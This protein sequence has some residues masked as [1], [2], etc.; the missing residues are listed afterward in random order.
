MAVITGSSRGIGAATAEEMAAQG[1][2]I[3]VAYR[4]DEAAARSVVTACEAKGRSAVAVRVDVASADD[5]KSLFAAADELGR[6]G[7]LVNNAAMLLPPNRVDEC[8]ATS[9]TR[10]LAVNVVG[11]FLCARE[12]IIRMSTL[13]GGAGGSIVNV[14]S[15]GSRHGA[16]GEHVDYA[17]SKGALDAM[18]WG[19]AQE[20]A[21]EG[22]RVNAVRPGAVET[23]I[24]LVAGDRERVSRRARQTPLGRVG[25]PI[26]VAR[27]IAWLCSNEASF[28]VG[29][30]VDVSGGR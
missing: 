28:V 15:I 29:A 5:V 17:A 24:H 26:E 11:P 23:D 13:H 19:L 18:T 1:W 2:D 3:C 7:A 14:S 20:V 27:A 30:I 22:V 9:L 25:Q 8:E 12:A 21:G 16:P 10:L 4:E 6:L